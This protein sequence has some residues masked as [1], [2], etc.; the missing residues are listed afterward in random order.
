[1]PE[2]PVIDSHVHVG[3]NQSRWETIR[4]ALEAVGID[5]AVLSADPTSY[6]LRGDRSIGGDLARPGGPYGLWYVGGDPFAGYGL[7]DDLLPR[8]LDDY[9]G[10]DWHCWFSEGY[11]YG[12]SDEV[13]ISQA[14]ELLGSSDARRAI[15]AIGAIIEAHLPIRLTESLP[16]TLALT[17][18]FPDGTF[19]IPHMGLRNGGSSRVLNALAD[20]RRVHFDTS[21]IEPNEGMVERVGWE[22]VLLGSD[23]PAGDPARAI[24]DVRS[25]SIPPDRIAAI[26]GENAR[27]VLGR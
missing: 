24:R 16:F 5:T 6:D 14:H 19:I 11:D 20:N 3:R 12:S 26:L 15:E 23:A 2:P 25:L 9:D 10:V 22:R 17:E 4:L 18:R 13:A 21:G 27:R 8:S 7:N 1:M